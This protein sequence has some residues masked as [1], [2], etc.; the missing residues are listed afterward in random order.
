MI[1]ICLKRAD[2]FCSRY[3][4]GVSKVDAGGIEIAPVTG[5]F[6]GREKT[7]FNGDVYT[8]ILI[9]E[10]YATYLD[11]G[12]YYGTKEPSEWGSIA[13]QL[14]CGVKAVV[15]LDVH[16][17]VI[18]PYF[19]YTSKYEEVEECWTNPE[20]GELEC[21]TMPGDYIGEAQSWAVNRGETNWCIMGKYEDLEA[22]NGWKAAGG[23]CIAAVNAAW[24]ALD[25]NVSSW[26]LIRTDKQTIQKDSAGSFSYYSVYGDWNDVHFW[27][28]KL[29][30]R[31]YVEPPE[32]LPPNSKTGVVVKLTIQVRMYDFTNKIWGEWAYLTQDEEI[33][34]TWG[35]K[36]A[37]PVVDNV[38][39]LYDCGNE[40]MYHVC[41]ENS[42]E[43]RCAECNVTFTILRYI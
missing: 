10:K 15:K 6:P 41:P 7:D 1:V 32:D 20:T 36:I 19:P 42:L 29:Y 39:L 28:D 18:D 24:S 34:L 43:K 12:A 31:L 27:R 33:S 5:L 22:S 30:G 9:G 25:G 16:E 11:A 13:D 4:V 38:P 14:C 37:T 21:W 26:P 40:N 17:A 8:A 2:G 3:T 23:T 35:W